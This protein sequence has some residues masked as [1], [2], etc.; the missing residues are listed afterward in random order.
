MIVSEGEI[1]GSWKRTVKNKDVIIE[2][3][4]FRKPTKK[5]EKDIDRAVKKFSSFIGKSI[6]EGG[7]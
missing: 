6:P 5:Q 4:Y 7:E 1:V 3:E 2:T